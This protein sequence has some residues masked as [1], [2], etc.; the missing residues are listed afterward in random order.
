MTGYT[1]GLVTDADFLGG[2][3]WEWDFTEPSNAAGFRSLTATL[4]GGSWA[5]GD[6]LL[7]TARTKVVSKADVPI[8]QNVGLRFNAGFVA[9]ATPTVQ[10]TYGDATVHAAEL[11][12]WRATVPAA[13]T[14]VQ[15]T[16]LVGAIPTDGQLTA[17]ISELGVFNLTALGLA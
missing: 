6:K 8:A 11:Y 16:A 9:S 5:V 17:R 10:L 14:T 15:L 12:A 3:A 2:K 7:F 13:T 4:A 1:E